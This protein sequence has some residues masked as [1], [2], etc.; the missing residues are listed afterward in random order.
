MQQ[1]RDQKAARLES[2]N[3]QLQELARLQQESGTLQ[4]K[5]ATLQ[6]HETGLLQTLCS[7]KLL[8]RD[9]IY[10]H[11]QLS[12]SGRLDS[13]AALQAAQ[14]HLQ[15]SMSPRTAALFASVVS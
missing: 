15:A 14:E 9:A 3:A 4:Q 6:E 2:V 13:L 1:S 12:D 7:N 11:G 8:V 10:W 5:L